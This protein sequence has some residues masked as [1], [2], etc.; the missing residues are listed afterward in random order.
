MFSLSIFALINLSVS[1]FHYKNLSVLAGAKISQRQ[2]IP[3]PNQLGVKKPALN[4][5]RQNGGAK[6]YP[7]HPL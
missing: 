5:R 3:A 7:T 4:N 6:K 2:N 1:Y